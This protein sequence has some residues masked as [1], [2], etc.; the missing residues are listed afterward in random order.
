MPNRLAAAKLRNIP[1]EHWQCTSRKLK[2]EEAAKLNLACLTAVLSR[3]L[4]PSLLLPSAK[5]AEAV[6]R[7][8]Q[9]V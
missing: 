7:G 1:H 8:H 9:G 5:G 3:P 4:S 6:P 2:T